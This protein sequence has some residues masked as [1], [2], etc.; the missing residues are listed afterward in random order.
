MLGS[1][2]IAIAMFLEYI[3]I[4]PVKSVVAFRIKLPV[5]RALRF[6]YDFARVGLLLM[7]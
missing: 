7:L 4:S 3:R 5:L 2:D 1:L 6:V